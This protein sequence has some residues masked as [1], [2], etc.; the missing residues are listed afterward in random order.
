MASTTTELTDFQRV[1]A[2]LRTSA[3]ALRSRYGD[4]AAVRRIQND[5]ERL[6]ID[7]AE[8]ASVVPSPR[9]EAGVGRGE[10]VVVPD[11]PYDPSLWE[12]VDDEGIGGQGRG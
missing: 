11:T 12:D 1:L 10:M 7:A 5:L 3:N 9:R 6:D 2:Q 4:D 8:L